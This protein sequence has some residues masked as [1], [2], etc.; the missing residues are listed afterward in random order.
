MRSKD[1]PDREKIVAR[2]AAMSPTRQRSSAERNK[3]LSTRSHDYCSAIGSRHELPGP[4]GK[5]RPNPLGASLGRVS[6]V[7][8]QKLLLFTDVYPY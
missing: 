8:V 7:L 1:R 4:S 5:I 3:T 6:E 2:M